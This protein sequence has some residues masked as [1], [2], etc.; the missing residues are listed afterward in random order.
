MSSICYLQSVVDG[1]G[2]GLS[3]TLQHWQT[4]FSILEMQCDIL[5]PWHVTA[6][7]EVTTHT[8]SHV[9]CLRACLSVGTSAGLCPLPSPE[10]ENL[11]HFTCTPL[12]SA[13]V[14]PI[15]SSSQSCPTSACHLPPPS[16]RDPAAQDQSHAHVSVCATPAA[17]GD[18]G[19][20]GG[21]SKRPA[22]MGL[23]S[24]ASIP[25][26][27]L[28][29]GEPLPWFTFSPSLSSPSTS[30][31]SLTFWAPWCCLWL[32]GLKQGKQGPL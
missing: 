18:R 25:S 24:N 21:T 16:A 17:F 19:T 31:C 1:L 3:K 28:A 29:P 22:F 32:W 2:L 9:M 10:I 11:N 20:G 8:S 4:H 5:W 12:S 27:R 15:T 13:A 23:W 7:Q 6:T 14:F 26:S 30:S